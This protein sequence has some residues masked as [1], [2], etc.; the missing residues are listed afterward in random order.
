MKLLFVGHYGI[1]GYVACKVSHFVLISF[2]NNRIIFQYSYYIQGICIW[3]LGDPRNSHHLWIPLRVLDS[4]GDKEHFVLTSSR[5][6]P[7]LDAG[8]P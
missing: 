5:K 3:M 8:R 4:E 2:H 7:P 6:P 1:N